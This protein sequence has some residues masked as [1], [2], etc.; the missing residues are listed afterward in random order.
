VATTTRR[1]SL[2]TRLAVAHAAAMIVVLGA[3]GIFTERRFSSALD[4][5][6]RAD[7]TAETVEF[8]TAAA[9]RPPTDSLSE[10]ALHWAST[11]PEPSGH[12]ITV[13]VRRPDGTLSIAGSED[14]GASLAAPV[15]LQ[16]LTKAPVSPVSTRVTS[17]TSRFQLLIHAIGASA[18]APPVATMV[19]SID[20]AS[21][22]KLRSQ[23][24]QATL[25]Q[26]ALA[27]IVAGLSTYFLLRRLMRGVAKLTE[28]ADEISM[29]DLD[30]RIN[31]AGP[32]DE[33]GQLA[34]TFDG[35]L[36]RL[37][38]AFTQ[39][40]QLL[41]EVSHQLRTPITVARGHLEVQARAGFRDELEV[42]HSVDIAMGELDHVNRL[43][44]RLL[45]FGTALERHGDDQLIELTPFLFDLFGSA[46]VLA[47]R[48]WKLDDRTSGVSFLADADKLRG[49]VLNLVENSVKATKPGDE[50]RIFAQLETGL[51]LGV[52]DEG[53]GIATE[54]TAHVFNRFARGDGGEGQGS[55]L[56][57]AIVKAVVDSLGGK[58]GLRSVAGVGTTVTLEIPDGRLITRGQD[59][60]G[61][62]AR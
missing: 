14:S 27:I 29:L 36:D 28:M 39:Q 43:I 12:M 55:G 38:L 16:W 5:D 57:L 24:W 61:R 19:L 10:F 18:T 48:V 9:N 8:E 51:L 45:N 47:T 62:S 56:G 52:S 54:N 20:L 40:A 26:A 31:Y 4:L 53:C 46:R 13:G 15:V 32:T 50:I 58:V 7:L 60:V 17:G 2:V 25:L 6:V 34:N 11:H 44:Q 22:N 49:A 41:A 59:R 23:Q 30:R 35:M 37:S 33:I 42:A 1:S 3:V 21:V